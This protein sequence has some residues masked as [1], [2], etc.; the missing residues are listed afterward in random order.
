MMFI[1]QG[2]K[3]FSHALT[4]VQFSARLK[5]GASPSQLAKHAKKAGH[6]AKKV[7][8]KAV[9]GIFHA[10]KA[11]QRAKNAVMTAVRGIFHAKKAGQLAKN[12]VMT[13]VRGIFHA[14]KAGKLA[15]NA[16]KTA[17]RGKEILIDKGTRF[18]TRARQR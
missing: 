13:A 2:H 10:K 1:A 17:V 18:Q 4:V 9:R 16:V 12:A 14:K 5:E 3:K 11:G 15:K 6:F 7:V 8:T